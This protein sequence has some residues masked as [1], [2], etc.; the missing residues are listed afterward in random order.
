MARRTSIVE[1]LSSLWG[2]FRFLAEEPRYL[3][4]A[5]LVHAGFLLMFV[6]SFEWTSKPFVSQPE[7]NVV[8]ATVVDE[9]A[10]QREVDKLREAEARRQAEEEAR[11]RRQREETQRAEQQRRQAEEVRKREEQRAAEARRQ[12]QQARREAEEAR[13][14]AEEA[15]KRE[16]QRAAEQRRQEEARRA[17]EQRRR[18]EEARRAE[19]QRRQEE[20]ARLAEEQRRRD[21][22]AA[23][24]RARREQ[25]EVERYVEVIRQQVERNWNKPA[26]WTAGTRCTVRV[27][28]IPGGDV[29]DVR[30][31]RSCGDPLFDSSVER[32]VYRASPLRVPPPDSGLFDRFRE[33]EFVFNPQG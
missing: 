17:E 14:Q 7:V 15:R 9:A 12:E 3:V 24:E 30:V 1:V 4:Y 8:Q 25:S 19:E 6:M 10:V 28:L 13:R 21:E 31:V 18:E 32:A 29:V 33:L 27:N 20:A 23:A 22:Q 26:N 16:E 2:A 5:L 11:L